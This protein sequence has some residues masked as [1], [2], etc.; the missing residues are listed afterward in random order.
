MTFLASFFVVLIF[1]VFFIDTS[2]QTDA[3]ILFDFALGWCTVYGNFCLW[4]WMVH[5]YG[6]SVA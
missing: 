2:G 6:T 1:T 3:N 5:K 4:Q